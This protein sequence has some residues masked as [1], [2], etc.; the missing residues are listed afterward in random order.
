ME[1]VE[2]TESH[3]PAITVFSRAASTMTGPDAPGWAGADPDVI[4]HLSQP[5]TLRER[6]G[7]PERRLFHADADERVVAF[8]ATRWGGEG[9]AE[10]AGIVVLQ[11][12]VGKVTGTPV[13]HEAI[14][15]L[16]AGGASSVCALT[17]VDNERVLGCSRARGFGDERNLTE[18]VDG[19]RWR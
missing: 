2:A 18:Y 17:E 19:P 9:S 12:M 5:E 8:A 13:L 14:D 3:I 7:G 10:P 16:R 4:E 11:E 1:F 15:R 6:I